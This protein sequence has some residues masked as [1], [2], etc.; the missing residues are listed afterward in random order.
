MSVCV[1]L[2]TG[3]TFSTPPNSPPPQTS[4]VSS[5]TTSSNQRLNKMSE[6]KSSSLTSY[7]KA[8][9]FNSVTDIGNNKGHRTAMPQHVSSPVKQQQLSCTHPPANLLPE[10]PNV[11][12]VNSSPAA[13]RVGFF[14][15]TAIEA[16][17]TGE[18]PGTTTHLVS[19]GG[20]GGGREEVITTPPLA[21]NT[22]QHT[23]SSVSKKPVLITGSSS[24]RRS[25]SPRARSIEE[26][27]RERERMYAPTI[28]DVSSAYAQRKA[29]ATPSQFSVLSV[30]CCNL[31]LIVLLHHL[32]L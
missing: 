7:E 4:S 2:P 32:F 16:T 3:D 14:D 29:S 24:E 10:Y 6:N 30:S 25:S 5:S 21:S 26:M 19:A 12:I 20:G 23:S 22:S 31:L 13:I 1:F 15:S 17:N 8:V 28:E 18:L 9:N 11:A 27:G